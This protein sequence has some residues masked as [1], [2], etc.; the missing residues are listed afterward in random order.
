ML[1]KRAIALGSVTAGLLASP[2]GLAVTLKFVVPS[3]ATSEASKVYFGLV[4][5]F[6]KNEPG[7]KIEFKA[8]NNWDDVVG[9]VRE[10]VDKKQNAGVF[11]AEVSQ[12]LELEHL[13]L[14]TPWDDVLSGKNGLKEFVAP[15]SPQFLGNS[16]CATKKLCGPPI[17]RSMPVALYNLDKLKE[18]GITLE[19]LPTT[20]S[21]AES[22][23]EKIRNH[24]NQPPFVLGGEWYDYLFEAMVIQAGGA[25]MVPKGNKV[26]LDTPE[27]VEALKYW[28]QLKDK[29]LLT[30]TQTWKETIKGFA[31]GLY[32]VT[33]YSSGGMETVRSIAK[34]GW[35]ADMLPKNKAYGVAVGGGN[36]YLSANMSQEEKDAAVKFAKFLYRPAVQARI[37]AGTGFF[38]VVDAAFSEPELS[39]RYTREEPF[40]RVRKQLKFVKPK[41]MATDN[42]KVREIVKK[43]IDRCLDEGMAPDKALQMAQKEVDQLLGQ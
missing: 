32:T 3:G 27:A 40:V 8:L 6:E 16:Y 43:S 11:V 15:I 17:V 35:M 22:M 30:R 25:L 26:T 2:I 41:I 4:S 37:S 28:R 39:E 12:T 7:V 38:P 23:L 21:A 33:Y 5:E 29:K 9:M 34:F 18:A 1:L 13:G 10:Q 42:L 24:T 19:Q 14:I 20:W 31:G 36:L